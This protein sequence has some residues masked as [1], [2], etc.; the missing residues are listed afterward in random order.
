MKSSALRGCLHWPLD[1]W[2]HLNDA[3][4]RACG[5]DLCRDGDGFVEIFCLDQVVAQELLACFRE[6]AVSHQPFAVAH[7]DAG[8]RRSRVQLR[9]GYILSARLD[10]LRK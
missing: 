1:E 9:T 7:P 8:R 10:L 4:G 5:W 2:P 6:R 3:Q